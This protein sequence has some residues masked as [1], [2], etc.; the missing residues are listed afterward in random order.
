M[1]VFG[2]FANPDKRVLDA[3]DR[4]LQTYETRAADAW[5]FLTVYTF[6]SNPMVSHTWTAPDGSVFGFDASATSYVS[7]LT[8]NSTVYSGLSTAQKVIFFRYLTKFVG[9]CI[10]NYNENYGL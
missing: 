1:P 2:N 7:A 8:F 10:K 4:Y 3:N 6:N 5:K 9:E